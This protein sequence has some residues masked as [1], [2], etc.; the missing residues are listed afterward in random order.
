[1]SAKRYDVEIGPIEVTEEHLLTEA[2]FFNYII[3]NMNQI[4]DIDFTDNILTPLE[5]T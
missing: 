4:I 5:V 2:G 1:M 3:L